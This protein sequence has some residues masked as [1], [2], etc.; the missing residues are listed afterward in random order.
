MKDSTKNI[1]K[2]LTAKKKSN[3]LEEV[4]Y[5]IKNQG[6]LNKSANIASRILDGMEE[7]GNISQRDLAKKVDLTPQRVSKILKGDANLTLQT[8]DKFEKVLGLELIRVTGYENFHEWKASLWEE[9]GEITVE[10]TKLVVKKSEAFLRAKD[11]VTKDLQ[12]DLKQN[13]ESESSYSEPDYSTA[14]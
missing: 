6:W 1:L 2:K 11:S 3:W 10:R 5:K 9:E 14:A 13:E 7:A 4:A 8:I 12:K